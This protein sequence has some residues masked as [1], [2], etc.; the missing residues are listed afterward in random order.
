MLKVIS[1][2]YRLRMSVFSL[3]GGYKVNQPCE[4]SIMKT[5]FECSLPG[6]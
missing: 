5:S 2:S 3:F 4:E 1:F 6:S